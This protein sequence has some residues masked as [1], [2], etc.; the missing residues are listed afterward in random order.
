MRDKIK[1]VLIK[2][3]KDSNRRKIDYL[4]RRLRLKNH[5]DACNENGMIAVV[6][7]GMDCDC[8]KYSGDVRIIPATLTHFLKHEQERA[9]GCDGP[10]NLEIVQPSKAEGIESTSEDLALRAFE[11][12]HPHLVVA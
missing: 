8:V 1:R 12:G 7:D 2:I 4:Q 11:N 5:I 3:V 9:N 10:F 6:E